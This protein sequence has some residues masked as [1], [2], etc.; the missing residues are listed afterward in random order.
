LGK[1][2]TV[3]LLLTVTLC[4][5]CGG[6]PPPEQAT[7]SAQPAGAQKGFPDAPNAC[8]VLTPAD[9]QQV[10]GVSVHGKPSEQLEGI[11]TTSTCEYKSIEGDENVVTI[12]IQVAKTDDPQ[13]NRKEYEDSLKSTA[14]A[15]Y[16]LDR[17]EGLSAPAVWN[18]DMRQLTVFQG[19]NAAI[20]TIY[21][22]KGHDPVEVAKALAGTSLPRM[23]P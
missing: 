14:G 13:T 6:S 21:D 9:L 10:L 4:P 5:G 16:Q 7:G 18:P 3:V 20:F 15:D 23:G 22:T 8:Q 19:Y 12:L 1:L 17:V 2:T 11:K